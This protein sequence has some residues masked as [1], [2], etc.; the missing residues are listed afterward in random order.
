MQNP[1]GWNGLCDSV[2]EDLE[3]ISTG[4]RTK[5]GAWNKI[6]T[7]RHICTASHHHGD[8]HVKTYRI[9]SLSL[10]YI[11]LLV[12]AICNLISDNWQSEIR[13]FPGNGNVCNAYSEDSYP[14]VA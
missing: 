13:S 2:I 6:F 5:C 9:L 10:Q 14:F 4:P 8:H 7:C 1:M 11:S 3:E 12:T